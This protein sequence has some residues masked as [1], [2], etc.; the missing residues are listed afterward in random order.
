MALDG[1]N[2]LLSFNREASG[3]W[4]SMAMKIIDITRGNT[5]AI[6]QIADLLIESFQES[7]TSW[8]TVAEAMDEVLESLR[9]G[10]VC[11][12][13]GF[14]GYARAPENTYRGTQSTRRSPGYGQRRACTPQ[15]R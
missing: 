6:E 11:D 14:R 1:V 10:R 7:A 12:S 9:P 8:R 15:R 3:C 13:R 5:R 2:R 4:A